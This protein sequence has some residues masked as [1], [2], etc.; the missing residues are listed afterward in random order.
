MRI[1]FFLITVLLCLESAAQIVDDSTKQV[2]GPN[3]I[4]FVKEQD[5]LENIEK[6]YALDTSIY[7]FERQSVVDRSDRRFQDLGVIGSAMTPI[8]FD[9]QEP[10]G[11]TSGYTAYTRYGINP[12]DIK[13]YDTK[14]PYIELFAMLGGRNRN[15]VDVSFSR[16]V[17]ENWN[18]GFDLFKTTVDKQLARQTKGDRQVVNSSF[19]GYTHYKHGKIPYQLM[20]NFTSLSHKVFEIGG[21]RPTVDSLRNDYFRYNNALLRL[22]EAQ[23]IIKTSRWHL[24]HDFSI[25]SKLQLYHTMDFYRET[26]YYRDFNEASTGG[27]DTYDDFY[28]QF[29]ID[30]DSTFQKAD[31]SAFS[32]EAGI[33]GNWSAVFYRFYARLRNV[34]NDFLYYSTNVDVQEKYLGGTIRFDWKD[35]FAVNGRAEYLIGGDYLLEGS[36]ASQIL[37]VSYS[38]RKYRA[39]LLYQDYFGNHHEW[40]NSFSSVFS[41]RLEGQFVFSKRMFDLKPKVVAQTFNNFLYFDESISPIQASEGILLTSLGGDFNFRFLNDKEEGW[42]LENEVLF[43]N[44]SGGAANA[45]RVPEIFYNGRLFWRGNWFLDKIPVEAG[46]DTHARSTYFANKYAPE[47]QQFYLQNEQEI[48][49]YLVADIFVNMKVDKFF[50]SVKWTH[51]NQPRNDGYFA[52]PFYPG[53]RKAIDVMVK[54]MFFD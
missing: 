38:S 50:F 30:A 19:A 23:A 28:P 33:K 17:N 20:L 39:P 21:A 9:V 54:W 13:Y 15:Q 44:V 2:Y 25:D 37:N 40:H 36:I 43:S 7:K 29:L 6:E 27:Y 32:N 52:T 45:M 8:F 12:G 49:G 34:K 42:H 26:N 3:T 24:Y 11:R 35:R 53:Q 46:L 16:N 1:F 22:D 5:V 51:F 31:F 14:S 18:I 41:N 10:I 48:F 4:R 47:I